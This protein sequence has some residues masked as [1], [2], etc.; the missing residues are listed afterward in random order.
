MGRENGSD[1]E[2]GGEGEWG[3]EG[4]GEVWRGKGGVGQRETG[5]RES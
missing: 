4:V 1:R 2:R 3:S 5:E